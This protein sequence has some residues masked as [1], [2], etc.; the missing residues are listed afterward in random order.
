[1]IEFN[2]QEYCGDAHLLFSALAGAA[3]TTA[4]DALMN[5]FDG[6]HFSLSLPLFHLFLNHSTFFSD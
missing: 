6:M 1:V 5:P 4:A 2:A 3:G